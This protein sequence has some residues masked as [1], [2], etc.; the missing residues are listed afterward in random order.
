MYK[1]FLPLLFLSIISC[2]KDDDSLPEEENVLK[3][4]NWLVP[5]EELAVGA[6]KDGIP[7]IDNPKFLNVE[8][9]DYLDDTDQMLVLKLGETIKAYPVRILDWHEIVNDQI[10]GL[11][12]AITYCPLTATGVCWN[13]EINGEVSTFGVSGFLHHSNLIAFDRLTDSYWSQISLNSLRGANIGRRL[14]YYQMVEMSWK[15][16]KENV[17]NAQI[18]SIDTGFDLP[19]SAYPY[20][21]YRTN[22]NFF[23]VSFTHDD[24]RLPAK[25]KVFGVIILDGAKVYPFPNASSTATTVINE[26]FRGQPIVVIHAPQQGYSAAFKS[27]LN[28]MNLQ[29]SVIEDQEAITLTDQLG[30]NWNFFGEAVSGPWE[31]QKLRSLKAFNGYWFMWAKYFPRVEIN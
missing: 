15:T 3:N 25:E 13:R 28:G 30:N 27:N 5:D 7:S 31:G 18:L 24:N 11:Q 20:Y 1:F 26:V 6:D 29:F 9:V 4:V 16:I 23:Y 2:S 17:P 22:N 19:Y 10:D 14:S 21:D 12:I 8:E